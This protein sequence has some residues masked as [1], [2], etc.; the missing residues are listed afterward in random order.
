MPVP[1]PEPDLPVVSLLPNGMGEDD[2]WLIRP[3]P[4]EL[5]FRFAENR[6][7]SNRFTTRG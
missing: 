7:L 2:G 3:N 5:V 4:E 6:S 1:S